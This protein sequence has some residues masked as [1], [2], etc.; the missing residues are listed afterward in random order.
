MIKKLKLMLIISLIILLIFSQKTVFA[1]YYQAL[2]KTSAKA[3]IAEPII[4]VE[5]LQ[6]A[7]IME[8]NKE[9]EIKQYSFIIKNYELDSNNTKRITEVGFLYDIEIKNSS[10]NFPIRYELYDV[11]SGEEILKGTN[12]VTRIRNK[13]KH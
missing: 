5:A 4:K 9:S 8:I 11:T 7:I 1:R 3:T 2:E 12:K 10:E 13:E 6:E